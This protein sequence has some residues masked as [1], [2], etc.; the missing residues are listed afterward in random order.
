[1]ASRSG[2]ARRW[3]AGGRDGCRARGRRGPGRRPAC[4]RRGG[5]SCRR[6]PA[7]RG[8]PR[9]RAAR[10]TRPSAGAGSRRSAAAGRARRRR[11]RRRRAR[12]R[13]SRPARGPTRCAASI[14]RS[15]VA[16]PRCSGVVT[17]EVTREIDSSTSM[18]GKWP[19]GR[20]PAGEHDV[21][22]EDGPGGVA[23]RVLH[24]V[25]LDQDGVQAGDAAVRRGAG[26]L[27]QARHQGEDAGRVAAGGG[28]LA[29]G[30]ADLALGHGHAGEAVHHQHDVLAVVAEPLGDPG[31]HERGAQPLDRRGVGR[32]DDDDG[33]WPGPRDRGRSR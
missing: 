24:V 16:S 8:G 27:E 30:Q 26:P 6:S 14:R 10:W 19:D 12:R 25:A 1:M 32:G 22:V 18:L 33:A 15:R 11:R 28:R 29:G 17:A 2:A 9:C 23:D 5:C 13:R 4:R 3:P 20:E 31:G 7:H 21:A